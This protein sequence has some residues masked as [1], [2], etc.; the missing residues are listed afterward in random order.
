MSGD[1]RPFLQVWWSLWW[2]TAT[3]QRGGR[4]LG[5]QRRSVDRGIPAACDGSAAAGNARWGW[6]RLLPFLR[7]LVLVYPRPAGG[8]WRRP[9]GGPAFRAGHVSSP[10]CA[11]RWRATASTWRPI[12]TSTGSGPTSRT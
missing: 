8:E 10:A 12:V 7:K 11:W 2:S 3:V 4:W 5:R 1:V 9:K 6:D